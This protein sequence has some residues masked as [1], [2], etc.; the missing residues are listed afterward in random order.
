MKCGP[1]W[2]Y[3]LIILVYM[4]AVSYGKEFNAFLLSSCYIVVQGTVSVCTGY[5]VGMEINRIHNN[6]SSLLNSLHFLL[7]IKSGLRL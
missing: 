2:L 5:G 1:C 7:L 4:A 6:H 3:Y